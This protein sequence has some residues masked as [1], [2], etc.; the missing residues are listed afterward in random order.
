MSVEILVSSQE[1]N[2][3]PILGNGFA[4]EYLKLITNQLH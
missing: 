4:T 1:C 3:L 2:F